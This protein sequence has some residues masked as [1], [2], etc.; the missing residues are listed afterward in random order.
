MARKE[1]TAA[2]VVGHAAAQ[3]KKEVIFEA[4]YSASDF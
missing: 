3:E 4:Q 1:S 2:G